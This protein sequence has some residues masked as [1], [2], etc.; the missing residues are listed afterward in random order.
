MTRW[1]DLGTVLVTG[2]FLGWIFIHAGEA[3]RKV[4]GLQKG[5]T[6]IQ[7]QTLLG[8]PAEIKKRDA[9]WGIEERWF[10]RGLPDL[11]GKVI[12]FVDGKFDR[13]EPEKK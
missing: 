3:N 13:I 6:P 2:I 8:K 1:H 7:V 10:Y 9:C 4:A 11:K 5:M 12:L